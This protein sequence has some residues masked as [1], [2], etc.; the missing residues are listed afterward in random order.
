MLLTIEFLPD[1]T[2]PEKRIRT[3]HAFALQF[4]G[5]D[6][7]ETSFS[8]SRKVVPQPQRTET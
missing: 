3:P 7:Q 1:F 6:D 4:A 5:D 8:L 2:P